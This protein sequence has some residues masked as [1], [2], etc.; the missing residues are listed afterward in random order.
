ML[1][2]VG[3]MIVDASELLDEMTRGG[4]NQDLG[5][6]LCSITAR[7]SLRH[8]IAVAG[9]AK[10]SSMKYE[11]EADCINESTAQERPLSPHSVRA[12]L[13]SPCVFR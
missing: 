9:A 3:L 2:A 6:W 5:L 12:D 13:S 1:R 8:C 7:T 10:K 11:E 4:E